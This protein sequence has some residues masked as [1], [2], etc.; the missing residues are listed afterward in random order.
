MKSSKNRTIKSILLEKD[1][2]FGRVSNSLCEA[3]SLFDIREGAP[4]LV[5]QACSPINRNN[6]VERLE[7]LILEAKSGHNGLYDEMLKISKQLLSMNI[8]NQEQLENFV[9]NYGK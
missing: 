7:L 1:G 6:L 5:L 2:V 8:F 3:G 4:P 9:Y